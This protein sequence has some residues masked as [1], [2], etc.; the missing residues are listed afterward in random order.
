MRKGRRRDKGLFASVL[1]ST[2]CVSRVCLCNTH[3]AICDTLERRLVL[4]LRRVVQALPEVERRDGAIG[5]PGLGQRP[6]LGRAGQVIEAVVALDARG[7]TA[8]VHRQHG[9]P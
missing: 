1:R 6:D 3:Y 2:Y 8:G 5:A 4:Y 7:P 9:E